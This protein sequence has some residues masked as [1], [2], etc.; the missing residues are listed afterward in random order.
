M[1]RVVPGAKVGPLG[2]EELGTDGSA[3][4]VVAS[5][6]PLTSAITRTTTNATTDS[7]TTRPVGNG[8]G[9]RSGEARVPL[10]DVVPCCGAGGAS[11]GE[12]CTATPGPAGVVTSDQRPPSHQ[13]TRPGAPSGSGYQPGAGFPASL[14]VE[15]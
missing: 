12:R 13:R 7:A 5:S 8:R 11:T 6:D 4:G 14:T 15:L 9:G 10:D 1:I 2:A 3:V